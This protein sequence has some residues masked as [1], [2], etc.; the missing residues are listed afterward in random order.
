MSTKVSLE[1]H[2]IHLLGLPLEAERR[3]GRRSGSKWEQII[4]S[5]GFLKVPTCADSRWGSGPP[6]GGLHTFVPF[7][8]QRRE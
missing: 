6:T 1:G 5:P 8:S 2:L 3:K 7:R 4:S